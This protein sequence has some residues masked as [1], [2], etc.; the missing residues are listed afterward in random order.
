MD[1]NTLKKSI[2]TLLEQGV[3]GEEE[4]CLEYTSSIGSVEQAYLTGVSVVVASDLWVP[5]TVVVSA[6][7]IDDS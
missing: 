4:V 2:D 1:L 3:D 5:N 6:K 7:E